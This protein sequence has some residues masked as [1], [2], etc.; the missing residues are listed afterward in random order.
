MSPTCQPLPVP[1]SGLAYYTVSLTP[2]SGRTVAPRESS[3]HFI[4]RNP[5]TISSCLPHH[6]HGQGFRS[7]VPPTT[8]DAVD[9]LRRPLTLPS[10]P[11][12]CHTAHS[13]PSGLALLG[14]P[15]SS[16]IHPALTSAL[17]THSFSAGA[18]QAVSPTCFCRNSP[19]NKRAS[20]HAS[21]P[22]HHRAAYRGHLHVDCLARRSVHVLC[23]ALAKP[24]R[25]DGIS[26]SRVSAWGGLRKQAS[27]IQ[28]EC[29]FTNPGRY[30]PSLFRVRR[31]GRWAC[32]RTNR[33][34][35]GST[36]VDQS[37]DL[38]D[39]VVAPRSVTA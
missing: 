35:L 3:D 24:A 11:D 33:R 30:L 5:E 6:L 36:S 38:A 15:A 23:T 13:P 1:A 28:V 21:Q 14:Q 34:C 39:E 27:H 37:F 19:P 7:F 32:S 22:F 20:V 10:A 25:I 18:Q 8:T 26:L 17:S 16:K 4:K 9:R 12:R 31:S 2:G 29:S